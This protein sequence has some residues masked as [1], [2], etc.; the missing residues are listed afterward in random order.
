MKSASLALASELLCVASL[1]S[2]ASDGFS[3]TVTKLPDP[4]LKPGLWEVVTTESTRKN[5]EGID[6]ICA[7]SKTQEVELAKKDFNVKR[8]ACKLKDVQSGKSLISYTA[9]CTKDYGVT[10]T[11][12]V[13]IE[14][15]FLDEFTRTETASFSIP[16]SME[17]MIH[18]RRFKYKGA[19]PK[20]MA[21]GDI[22]MKFRD[23]QGVEKW[24]RYNPPQPSKAPPSTSK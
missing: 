20:D 23:S 7:G 18:T 8:G 4:I 9:V 13:S 12:Q 15:D 24:N 14:G 1:M 3:A 17:G 19:C 21:P 6:N 10:I 11:S 5:F 2:F 16:V 22:I